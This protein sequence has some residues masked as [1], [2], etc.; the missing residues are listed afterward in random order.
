MSTLLTSSKPKSNSFLL[1]KSS[2]RLVEPG[3]EIVRNFIDASDSARLRVV[4]GLVLAN[5]E[6]WEPVASVTFAVATGVADENA[7]AIFFAS[8]SAAA[9]KSIFASFKPRTRSS[10]EKLSARSGRG[11]TICHAS[12]LRPNSI[13]LLLRGQIDLR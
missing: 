13:D 10:T 5:F 11:F 1:R 12:L 8:A 7:A 6:V 2:S 4:V 9:V 3:S